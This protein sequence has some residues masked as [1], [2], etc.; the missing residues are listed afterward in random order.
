MQEIETNRTE[1]QNVEDSVVCEQKKIAEEQSNTDEQ[2]ALVQPESVAM[3]TTDE[4]AIAKKP[5]KKK[6]TLPKVLIIIAAVLV[7]ISG[8]I[9]VALNIEN[10]QVFYF[11]MVD[12]YK[13]PRMKFESEQQMIE[14]L[15][16][17]W[18]ISQDFDHETNQ[19][20]NK[21]NDSH[22]YSTLI[23]TDDGYF[24]YRD[25]DLYFAE[26]L[27]ND[28]SDKTRG[29]E[30]FEKY[31]TFA[32]YNHELMK[33]KTYNKSDYS[34]GKVEDGIYVLKSGEL[35]VGSIFYPP[36]IYQKTSDYAKWPPEGLEED[37][38]RIKSAV[39][40]I[41]E[42]VIVNTM[43]SQ[44]YSVGIWTMSFGNLLDELCPDYQVK[45]EKY[46]DIKS[47]CASYLQS[48]ME[49]EYKDYQDT[50][51]LITVSGSVLY[52]IDIPN[53]YSPEQEL[54]AGLLVFDE[55]ANEIDWEQT[56]NSDALYNS[57]ILYMQRGY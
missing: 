46:T 43:R 36:E 37:F 9:T 29:K 14:Y 48:M 31:P 3:T 24:D 57:S 12:E 35:R 11:E 40:D 18:G 32:E 25:F 38:N 8:G 17:T 7:L 34:K 55:D 23:F 50:T 33:E 53:Y 13:Y 54:F 47:S 27:R 41:P 5:K 28:K 15:K 42:S 39:C 56:L 49:N 19:W 21:D 20:V 30:F 51:Y 2:S 52:N 26:P 6:L 4:T 44:K 45:I 10:I 22:A 1:S 16:G